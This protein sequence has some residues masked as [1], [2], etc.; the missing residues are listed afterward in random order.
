MPT[1]NIEKNASIL[2]TFHKIFEQLAEKYEQSGLESKGFYNLP[3][4]RL[5]AYYLTR[6][7]LG[8]AMTNSD[9]TAGQSLSSV[10][11]CVIAKYL[12]T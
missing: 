9:G 4:H 5:Y 12:P 3:I 1:D 10:F 11:K 6:L 7:L 2:Q 8:E